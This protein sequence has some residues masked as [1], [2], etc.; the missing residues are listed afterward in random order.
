MTFDIL[1]N[2]NCITENSLTQINAIMHFFSG[3]QL[4]PVNFFI[5]SLDIL[6]GLDAIK[7]GLLLLGPNSFWNRI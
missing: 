7:S 5:K 1:N 2:L 6:Q 4:S 3:S